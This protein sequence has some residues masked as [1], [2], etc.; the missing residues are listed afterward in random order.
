MKIVVELDT[1]QLGIVMNAIEGMFQARGL[2]SQRLLDSEIRDAAK[3]WR[4]GYE[5]EAGTY[6]YQIVKVAP[7]Y[8][9][10]LA[11]WKGAKT[12]AG[13]YLTT[14]S[15]FEFA[16]ALEAARAGSTSQEVAHV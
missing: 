13:E 8:R 14:E 7:V 2:R 4:P 1:V 5:E 11:H 12:Q 3:H 10:L 16:N 9:Q 15:A 6:C